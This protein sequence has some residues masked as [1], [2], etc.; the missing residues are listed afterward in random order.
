VAYCG[1]RHMGPFAGVG[2]T[3]LTPAEGSAKTPA[4]SQSVPPEHQKIVQWRANI[5]ELHD[6]DFVDGEIKLNCLHQYLKSKS[7]FLQAPNSTTFLDI[8]VIM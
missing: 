2:I 8:Y 5:P 6:L 3:R 4:A 7:K 1:T